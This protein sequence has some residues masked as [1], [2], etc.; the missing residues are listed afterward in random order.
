MN[1]VDKWTWALI[2]TLSPLENASPSLAKF[3]HPYSGGG[4]QFSEFQN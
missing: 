1:K 4:R 2:W 3:P